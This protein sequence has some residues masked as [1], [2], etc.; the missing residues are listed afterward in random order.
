MQVVSGNAEAATGLQGQ[1]SKQ[2]GH[3]VFVEPI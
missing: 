3:I 2:G 1:S